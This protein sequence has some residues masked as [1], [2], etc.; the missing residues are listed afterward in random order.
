MTNE[1]KIR[2]FKS[3]QTAALT[4]GLVLE[5]VRTYSSNAMRAHIDAAMVSIHIHADDLGRA[6]T[7]LIVEAG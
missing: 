2:V 6:I 1:E 3:M 7:Q 4:Q 5:G